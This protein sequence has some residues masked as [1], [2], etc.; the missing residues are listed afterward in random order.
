LQLSYSWN[1]RDFLPDRLEPDHLN[2][3]NQ[4]C[5]ERRIADFPAPTVSRLRRDSLRWPCGSG[6]FFKGLS[7]DARTDFDSLST[8]FL[9][10]SAIPLISEEQEPYNILFLL[11]GQVD[12]SMNSSDGRRLLLA[13]AGAGDILGLTSAISG[14]PSGIRAETRNPCMIASMRRPDFLDFLLRYPDAFQNVLR[15][16]SL[17]YTRACERLRILGLASV[18]PARLACLLLEWSRSGQQ[19]KGGTRIRLVLTHKEIGECIGASRETVSRALTELKSHALVRQRGSILI[20]PSRSALAAYAGI[21][22]IPNPNV[23]GA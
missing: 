13:V 14:D 11:E 5:K 16:L 22:S 23:P 4:I 9:C 1:R 18:V 21:D 6:Q 8:L 20:V 7:I 19:T 17:Q 12:I 2:G 3:K 10:P 15:E